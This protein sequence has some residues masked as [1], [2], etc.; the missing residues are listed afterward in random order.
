MVA[1]VW[2]IGSFSWVGIDNLFSIQSPPS[3]FENIS[4][5]C[6][7]STQAVTR[8]VKSEAPSRLAVSLCVPAVASVHNACSFIHPCLADFLQL[9]GHTRQVSGPEPRICCSPC[10]ECASPPHICR[11]KVSTSFDFLS[12]RV[13]Q[14][15]LSLKLW[16]VLFRFLCGNFPSLKSLIFY[17][18]CV[19][20][21]SSSLSHF[22]LFREGQDVYV[23]TA[24]LIFL[25]STEQIYTL[26]LIKHYWLLCC[27]S[28]FGHI[29]T[30]HSSFPSSLPLRQDLQF[31]DENWRQ[32]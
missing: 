31:P 27:F 19:V 5:S 32:M 22:L 7:F 21:F 26:A 29:C 15:V 25:Y 16:R 30:L 12:L 1:P 6:H 8:R 13:L 2:A 17:L 4:K 23:D 20:L 14:R 11:T 9:L 18:F 10:L 28:V 24:S 3:S